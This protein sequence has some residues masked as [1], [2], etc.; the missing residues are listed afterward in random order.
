MR[1][2]SFIVGLW[3]KNGNYGA[4]LRKKIADIEFYKGH[5]VVL[6]M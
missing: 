3:S 2:M 5:H 1:T 4:E 6:Q